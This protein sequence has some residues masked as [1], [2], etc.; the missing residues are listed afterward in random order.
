MKNEIKQIIIDTI[1]NIKERKTNKG[2]IK[3][4]KSKTKQL[5][6]LLSDP[7]PI[8][9]ECNVL[10]DRLIIRYFEKN[11]K[12]STNGDYIQQSINKEITPKKLTYVLSELDEQIAN[13]KLIKNKLTVIKQLPRTRKNTYNFNYFDILNGNKLLALSYNNT[14]LTFNLP[15]FTFDLI[16]NLTF[17]DNDKV[18]M[19]VSSIVS[20]PRE[21]ERT[22]TL[23]DIEFTI[24]PDDCCDKTMKRESFICQINDLDIEKVYET[25][26]KITNTVFDN[27]K[28]ITSGTNIMKY[29]SRDE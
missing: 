22:E 2:L 21:T 18:N 26:T 15:P 25:F 5:E 23:N 9:I 4:I 27:S 13:Y 3:E 20:Y 14:F 28:F 11:Y 7:L 1:D 8:T 10:D 16:A 29:E 17:K 24:V 19:D 12:F 6:Q